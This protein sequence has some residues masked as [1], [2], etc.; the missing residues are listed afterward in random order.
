MSGREERASGENME[1]ER[2]RSASADRTFVASQNAQRKTSWTIG[3]R[4]RLQAEL[5]PERVAIIGSDFAPL[6]YR[7]LQRQ[8]D[9]VRERLGAAGFGPDARIA[10]GL[11]NSAESALTIL[12]IACSMT[13]IPLD[14]KLTAGEIERCLLNARPNAVIVP[15]DVSTAARRVAQG[16]GIPLIE[17]LPAQGGRLCLDFMAP[18][19]GAAS[20]PWEPDPDAPAYILHTSGTT[21]E[22]NLVPFSHRN[23]L[24]SAERIEAWFGLTRRDRCLNVS[25]VYY[26]HALTTTV[27]PPLLTGGSVAFPTSSFNVDIGEWFGSLEPTWYSAGP[28][29]HLAVME[30][31]QLQANARTMHCL[32]FISSAGARLPTEVQRGLEDVLGIPVLEHYGSSETAQISANMPPPGASKAGT[33]GRPW[34]DTIKIVDED[35]RSL[36]VGE[37]GEILVRGPSV[38]SGYINAPELNR[39]VLRD[40]WYRT[41]DLGSLDAE[42][43]L[44]LHARKRELINR[45][46]EKIAP[47]E[48]DH[49]LMRHPEVAEAAAYAVPHPRLGEDIAAAVVLRPGATVTPVELRAFLAE[50]LAMF[51]IPRRITIVDRLPK[52]ITGKVQRAGLGEI[53]SQRPNNASP[54]DR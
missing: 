37:P 45:G 11:T 6:S 26:S 41:G 8:L 25:P 14:P 10:V 15:R 43:F 52:G 31:A 24:A 48:I 44:S 29:L 34:P 2:D 22:P 39:S 53:M 5:H 7:E 17:A 42:G 36:A 16:Q 23:A 35:G 13:A 18:G 50:Q 49:A 46:A 3:A 1:F 51:K 9:D 19:I 40:G 27:V 12:A 38:M 20:P 33:C 54:D 30:K 4:I 32:R 28:T 21:A 47:I